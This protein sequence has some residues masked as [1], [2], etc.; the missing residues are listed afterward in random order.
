LT[1]SRKCKEFLEKFILHCYSIFLDFLYNNLYQINSIF[2][3]YKLAQT[4][5]LVSNKPSN[6]YIWPKCI[7]WCKWT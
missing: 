1:I 6:N 2:K 7:I 3:S 5:I 4:K